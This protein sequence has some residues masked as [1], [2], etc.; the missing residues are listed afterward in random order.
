MDEMS[1]QTK[2]CQCPDCGGCDELATTT[3]DGG[4]HVCAECASYATDDD[5]MTYCSRCDEY[6]DAGEWTGGGMHGCGTAWVSRPRV[7]ASEV[8]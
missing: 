5:G 4:N 3:D 7:C 1:K 8:E 2:T 6:E